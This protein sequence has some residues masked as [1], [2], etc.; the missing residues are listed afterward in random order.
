[1]LEDPLSSGLMI[2]LKLFLVL[3]LVLLNGL[4]VA[5]EFAFVKAR[6][7]RISQLAN[8]GNV[9]AKSALFGVTHLDSY[10]SVCQLGI[11]LSSLGL[12]W[13]G[14]P[15]VAQLI[16]PLLHGLGITSPTVIHSISFVI[17]FTFITFLHVVFGE[18]APKSLAIQKAESIAMW[19]AFPMRFFYGLFY[20]G[21][22]VLNGTAN[23]FLKVLGL[24]PATEKEKTHSQE[25]LQ[26][27]ISESYMGGHLG[28]KEKNLLQNVFDFESTVAKD[29]MVPRLDTVFLYKQNSFDENL[30]IAFENGHTRYPICDETADKVVGLIHIK[31]LVYMDKQK[32]IE[33]ITRKMMFIPDC[34]PLDELLQR[35]QKERQ[36]MAVLVDEYGINV[37]IITLEDVL[38]ELVGDIQDEFDCEEPAIELCDNGC[39][40][41][42]GMTS[43]EEVEELLNVDLDIDE[44]DY[45]TLAG[46]IINSLERI[47][48]EG[49]IVIYDNYKFEVCKMNDMRVDKVIISNIGD[50]ACQQSDIKHKV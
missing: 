13:L 2:A 16:N 18:L 19:L 23:A 22:I 41:I 9:R 44:K 20:P 29:V 33:D 50:D 34:M 35:F 25:E 26:M 42:S 17:A 24:P 31:D 12:G 32:S 39:Y 30:S 45:S 49:D 7:T 27:L 14:E 37:G 38:E 46:F 6:E 15:A 48:A 3:L 5:A 8:S 28:E 21:V 47:P 11:T 36:Q 1:M 10:L 4:F 43:L 40:V